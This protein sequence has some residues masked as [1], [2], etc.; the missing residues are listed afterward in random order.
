MNKPQLF[1]TGEHLLAAITSTD[2]GMIDARVAGMECTFLIDSGA[3]VNTLTESAFR[4]LQSIQEYRDGIFNLQ[5]DSDLPLRAY[6]SS[7]IG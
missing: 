5:Y 2:E 1:L 6:A 4:A 3:Q 7:G